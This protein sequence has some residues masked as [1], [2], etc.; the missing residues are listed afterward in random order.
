MRRLR[1]LTVA[2]LLSVPLGLAVGGPLLAG[3]PAGRT[4]PFAAD[5][6]LGTDFVGRDVGQQVLLGGRSVVAVAVA[7]T[8]LAYLVG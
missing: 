7:A 5:G 4:F 2:A 3:E 8:L 1:T 6:P